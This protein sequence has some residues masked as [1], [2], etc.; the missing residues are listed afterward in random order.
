MGHVIIWRAY[1]SNTEICCFH[2]DHL[3]CVWLSGRFRW[4]P[5][6]AAVLIVRLLQLRHDR[7][8]SPAQPRSDERGWDKNCRNVGFYVTLGLASLAY[9]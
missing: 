1:R 5:D 3:F 9:Y 8:K 7:R 6:R 4:L 2:G